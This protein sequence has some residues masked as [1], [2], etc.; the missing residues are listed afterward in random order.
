MLTARLSV[1]NL[2]AEFVTDGGVFRAVDGVSFEV[3]PGRTVALVGESGCGKTVTA[4]SVL[5]L[6]P[7]PPAS[8]T[9]DAVL[10]EGR[11]LFALSEREMRRVRGEQVTYVFQEPM[12]SL[13]PVHS[14]GR[15]IV[16]V[17]VVHGLKRGRRAKARAVE[18]LDLVG[19]PAPAE[20]CDAFPH[21]LSSGMRQRVMVAM[22][23]AGNPKLLVADEPT[24]MLDVTS[25]AQLVELLGRL[26]RER[27]MSILFIT[28]DLG[29]VAQFAHEVVVMYSGQV[30]ETASVEDVLTS[31][32]HPYTRA[33]VAALPPAHAG[34]NHRPRRLKTTAAVES[35]DAPDQPG[36]RFAPRCELRSVLGAGTERCHEATPELVR[37]AT[38]QT[39]RC[40][41]AGQGPR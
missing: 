3:P 4:L 39:V 10:F 24:A 35:D 34:A 5:R 15:Q 2:T 25:Q 17:L 29:V 16:D 21:Q 31:P 18:L 41:F 26:Q 14:V 37:L 1:R 8:L 23:L 27:D 30:L 19:I 36:C 13:N 38:G 40:H 12:I 20:H 11:D 22:A 33:L 7:D 6:L 9:A 32:G 28:R